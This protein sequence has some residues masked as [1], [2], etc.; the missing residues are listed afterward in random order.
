[1]EQISP[2]VVVGEKVT[3]TNDIW[4]I[5]NYVKAEFYKT[6]GTD[7]DAEDVNALNPFLYSAD[8]NF[9]A[10]YNKYLD[11]VGFY[12]VHLENNLT[13]FRH[14]TEEEIEGVEFIIVEPEIKN[15]LTDVLPEGDIII[16]NKNKSM[17]SIY[18]ESVLEYAKRRDINFISSVYYTGLSTGQTEIQK[19]HVS[20]LIDLYNSSK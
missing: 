3:R 11:A 6:S 14:T 9:V 19:I 15:V 10:Q 16:K 8:F 5:S 12:K 1:M 13:I 2:I 18:D 7:K 4:K 20:E 17:H